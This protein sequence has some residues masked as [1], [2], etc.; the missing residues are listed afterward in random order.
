MRHSMLCLAL[1]ALGAAAPVAAAT[2]YS[3]N[4]NS[5]IVATIDTATGTVGSLDPTPF[6]PFGNAVLA[7]HGSLLYEINTPPSCDDEGVARLTVI[8]PSGPSVVS[9]FTLLR[10][11]GAAINDTRIGDITGDGTDVFV[12]YRPLG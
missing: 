3:I 4:V 2:L 8:D 10:L 1:A 9:G 6:W 7:H 12:T 11:G 5:D